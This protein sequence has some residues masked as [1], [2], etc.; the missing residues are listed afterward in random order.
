MLC[1]LRAGRPD[2]VIAAYTR[3]CK[4]LARSG[5]ARHPSEGPE[6]FRKRA[7]ASRPELAQPISSISARYI[8]LRYGDNANDSD[9]LQLRREVAS[10]RP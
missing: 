8:R 7:I 9:A 6:A 3:F 2:P 1:K 4:Q 5:V 10:F